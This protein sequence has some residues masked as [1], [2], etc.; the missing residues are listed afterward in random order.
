MLSLPPFFGSK[1][2]GGGGG[3]KFFMEENIIIFWRL[4]VY[5]LA[6]LGKGK[7]LGDRPETGNQRRSCSGKRKE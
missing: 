3:E 2:S 1:V 6:V 7:V 5:I 4:Y